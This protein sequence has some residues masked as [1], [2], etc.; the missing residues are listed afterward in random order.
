[1]NRS[2][3]GF[4]LLFF[5]AAVLAQEP[6]PDGKALFAASLSDLADK[7]VPMASLRGRPLVVNFWA[8]WCGPCREE[9]PQ[10]A[11]RAARFRSRGLEVVGIAIEDQA[12]AVRDFART[13]GMD[14]RILLAKEQGIPLL[15]ASGDPMAGLPFT[16]AIDQRGN[17][18]FKKVGAMKPAEMDTAFAAA[19]KQ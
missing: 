1:M 15:Q 17:V 6:L 8:R 13:Y 3:A 4:V 18:V 14:Y 16:L 11:L 19:L 9:I 2:G 10:L 12:G 7:P 5:S